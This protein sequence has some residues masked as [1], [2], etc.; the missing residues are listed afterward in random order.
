MQETQEIQ[1]Q[2]LDQE[3]PLEEEMAIHF[4]ILGKFHGQRLLEG[5]SPWDHKELDRNEHTHMLRHRSIIRRQ[6]SG[7]KKKNKDFNRRFTKKNINDTQAQ[8]K[9]ST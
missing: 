7:K 4:S 5:Y 8:K 6:K 2:T 9:Y 3:D 1:V